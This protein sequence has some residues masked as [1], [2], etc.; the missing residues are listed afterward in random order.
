[1]ADIPEISKLV[2]QRLQVSADAANAHPDANLL[3]AYAEQ[4]LSRAERV[5]VME[6]LSRCE[7][8][9]EVVALVMPQVAEPVPLRPELVTPVSSVA[10][11]RRRS[12]FSDQNLLW[13]RLAATVTVAIGIGLTYYATHDRQPALGPVPAINAPA[14]PAPDKQAEIPP[15]TGADKVVGSEDGAARKEK[16]ERTKAAEPVA[17][18]PKNVPT[19]RAEIQT[20]AS[21]SVSE[22]KKAKAESSKK[23][24][25]VAATRKLGIAG[26]QTASDKADTALPSPRATDAMS[27]NREAAPHVAIAAE[28]PSASI[29][30]RK[31]SGR[32]GAAGG[33]MPSGDSAGA[34][35]PPASPQ[36]AAEQQSASAQQGA[37][38][39]TQ[40][41]PSTQ[42]SQQ[43]QATAQIRPSLTMEP[44]AG[45]QANAPYGASRAANSSKSNA[46]RYTA[47]RWTISPAGRLQKLFSATGGSPQSTDAQVGRDV[48]F[49]AVAVIGT[50]VWAG[51]SGHQLFYSRDDGTHWTRVMG[52][53]QGDITSMRFSDLKHGELITSAGEHWTTVDGGEHWSDAGSAP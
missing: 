13:A 6:H 35:S 24:D 18:S 49:R 43:K 8:C 12:W 2:R 46:Y 21:S 15:S 52:D 11:A 10:G 32:A 7:Q 34:A 33:K 27:A 42:A 45:P 51:G 30:L 16:Q 20:P 47:S 36:S 14:A 4:G 50:H 17:A 22:E 41:L 9:R 37:L 44:M 25:E 40:S 1:M 53:W 19:E 39:D 28:T 38:S 31:D 5:S 48:V 23:R 29:K 3:A 26:G